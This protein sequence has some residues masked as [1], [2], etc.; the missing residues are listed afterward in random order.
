MKA[1][2][3][4]ALVSM[5][6]SPCAS[7]SGGA[8]DGSEGGAIV[9]CPTASSAGYVPP[10]ELPSGLACDATAQCTV[11]TATPC[12]DPTFLPPRSTWSCDCVSGVWACEFQFV[13]HSVCP[14]ADAGTD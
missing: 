5:L 6:F 2:I 9:P 4:T 1:L 12:P 14:P 13:T 10:S 7:S 3:A 8:S 11:V